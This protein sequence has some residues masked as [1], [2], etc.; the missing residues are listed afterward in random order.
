[1]DVL[2]TKKNF[3]DA[4]KKI[5]CWC[6]YC[7]ER[8]AKEQIWN[9]STWNINMPNFLLQSVIQFTRFFLFLHSLFKNNGFPSWGIKCVHGLSCF[10]RLKK[11]I[12]PFILWSHFGAVK[13]GAYLRVW[14]GSN[15][16][17]K[18]SLESVFFILFVKA[19]KIKIQ[20]SINVL[21]TTALSNSWTWLA[22]KVSIC[23][24]E[25]PLWM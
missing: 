8:L 24:L 3:A 20:F 22:K 23:F 4:K 13:M 7:S 16:T 2:N 17:G 19:R 10:T 15:I 5:I 6:K 18:C 11:C 25:Q 1:M 14:Q 9:M 21:Y 12:C